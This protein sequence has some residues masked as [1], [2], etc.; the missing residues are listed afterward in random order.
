[1]SDEVE[2]MCIFC[3]AAPRPGSDMCEDCA[4]R[5]RD[6]INN[7]T[8]RRTTAA[9]ERMLAG[10]SELIAMRGEGVV[11]VS[12]SYSGSG[13]SGEIDS[14]EIRSPDLVMTLPEGPRR[15]RI[16]GLAYACLHRAFAGWETNDGST[17]SISIDVASGELSI[18][19]DWNVMRQENDTHTINVYTDEEVE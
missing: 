4:N 2:V 17:G 7:S 5:N 15:E 12:I 16:E 11:A 1:M 8:R 3:P 6:R 10:E 18:D 14:V 13:D 9:S 19:H